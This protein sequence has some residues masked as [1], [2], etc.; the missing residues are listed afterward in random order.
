MAEM[1]SLQK[2]QYSLLLFII[3]GFVFGSMMLYV[4]V[5]FALL[6]FAN[7][8]FWSWKIK[9]IRCDSCGSPLAPPMGS[10]A[11]EIFGSFKTTEC[12]SCGA[13]LN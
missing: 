2:Y 9:T 7:I 1:N 10:S 3:F 5:S 11:S 13:K 12:T 6:F 4:H 8:L